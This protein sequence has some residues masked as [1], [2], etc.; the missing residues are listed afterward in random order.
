MAYQTPPD[1][2]ELGRQLMQQY[3]IDTSVL[4]N[5]STCHR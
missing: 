3:H 5:C 4:T 1:Q 2:A